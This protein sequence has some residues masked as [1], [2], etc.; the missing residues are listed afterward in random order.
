LGEKPQPGARPSH[1][2][3][4]SPFDFFETLA[5]LASRH[6][7]RPVN[8]SRACGALADAYGRCFLDAFGLLRVDRRFLDAFGLL[9]V[10]R[11]FPDAFGLL[12]SCPHAEVIADL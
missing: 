6:A 7:S 5:L 10:E 2:S 4:R 3:L 11:C 8:R 12:L 1:G 9:R